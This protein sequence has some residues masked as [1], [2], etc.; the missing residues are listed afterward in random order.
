MS[1]R[2][3]ENLVE[4]RQR[5]NREIDCPTTS[6][7]QG[8]LI[9]WVAGVNRSIESNINQQPLVNKIRLPQTGVRLETEGWQEREMSLLQIL[10]GV[11][12]AK[13][14]Q[15][16]YW[17][18]KDSYVQMSQWLAIEYNILVSRFRIGIWLG[19]AGIARR[20]SGYGAYMHSQRPD[21]PARNKNST[22]L[23][24][25]SEGLRRYHTQN[26]EDSGLQKAKARQAR[27][28]KA[29]RKRETIFGANPAERLNQLHSVERK[30]VWRIAEELRVSPDYI[31]REMVRLG[32][33]EDV[34]LKGEQPPRP[35]ADP[36]IMVLARER[37]LLEQ[38][39]EREQQVLNA[40]YPLEDVPIKLE[41]LGGELGITRQG[42]LWIEQRAIRKIEE[43]IARDGSS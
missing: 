24:K 14:L 31:R 38:L 32:I 21:N 34:K 18:Q 33:D 7:I 1:E 8:Q 11:D 12:Y 9:D 4:Q 35:G 26:P 43:A 5:I 36:E 40:R 20:S 29:A 10:L 39:S 25:I 37:G 6:L 2:L 16:R 27:A 15:D 17:G 30:A 22:W 3:L 19:L 23:Q 41:T 42:I 13:V 28:Q